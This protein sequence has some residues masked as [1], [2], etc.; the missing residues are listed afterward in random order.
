MRLTTTGVARNFDTSI[1]GTITTADLPPDERTKR[2][3][4]IASERCAHG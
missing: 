3:R 4:F 2:I 1:M